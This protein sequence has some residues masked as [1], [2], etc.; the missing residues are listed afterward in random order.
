MPLSSCPDPVA[1]LASDPSSWL[2]TGANAVPRI[3]IRIAWIATPESG[4]AAALRARCAATPG[5][6]PQV[7]DVVDPSTFPHYD[8]LLSSLSSRAPGLSAGL[9]LCAAFAAPAAVSSTV[10]VW[11]A[12]LRLP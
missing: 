4:T 5:I 11:L 12:G 2:Q 9:D 3:R 7:I 6:P 8:P 1:G 10:S